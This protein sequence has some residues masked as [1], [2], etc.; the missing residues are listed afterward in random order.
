MVQTA[1]HAVVRGKPESGLEPLT[2]CLQGNDRPCVSPVSMRVSGLGAVP[3]SRGTAVRLKV[4]NRERVKS[5]ISLYS[6]AS[7]STPR[8]RGALNQHDDEQGN[9]G[10]LAC[11]DGGAGGRVRVQDEN[12]HQDGHAGKEGTGDTADRRQVSPGS[13]EAPCGEREVERERM[14]HAPPNSNKPTS[15]CAPG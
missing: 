12:G 7:P 1:D 13:R 6:T 11:L 5:G 15:V 14:N 3:Y 2:P 10:R 4:P 9:P 8:R